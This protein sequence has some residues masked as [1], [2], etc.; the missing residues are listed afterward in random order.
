MLCCNRIPPLGCLAR[1]PVSD[2]R[3]DRHPP[4]RK[5]LTPVLCVHCVHRLGMENTRNACLSSFSR[6]TAWGGFVRPNISA[7]Y[8]CRIHFMRT[9]KLIVI[10]LQ[11]FTVKDVNSRYKDTVS[12][13]K[14]DICVFL[15]SIYCCPNVINM[16]HL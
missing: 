15:T 1:G 14:Q 5:R 11:G 6:Q 16:K 8:P 7:D 13:L 10:S 4:Q 2:E 3:S 9:H 12:E